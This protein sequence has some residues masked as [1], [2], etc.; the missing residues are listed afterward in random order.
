MFYSTENI[1]FL[2]DNRNSCSNYFNMFSFCFR[3][4][5]CLHQPVSGLERNIGVP[6]IFHPRARSRRQMTRNWLP[7]AMWVMSLNPPSLGSGGDVW[8][9]ILSLQEKIGKFISVLE[10]VFTTLCFEEL[11]K[12]IEKT[13]GEEKQFNVWSH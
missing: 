2:S 7:A 11:R 1:W 4:H 10:S 5:P 12:E 8:L 13:L 3:V 9:N 6:A